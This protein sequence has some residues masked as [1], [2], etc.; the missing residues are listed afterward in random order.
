MA[1]PIF[2]IHVDTVTDFVDEIAPRYTGLRFGAISPELFN[3]EIRRLEK[4]ENGYIRVTKVSDVIT[5]SFT[6][7]MIG[8][9]NKGL[10]RVRNY[11]RENK[12]KLE[13]STDK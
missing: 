9:A 7:K 2:G 13:L 3:A 11:I 12:I 6:S 4:D 10:N 5:D 1:Q 8:F